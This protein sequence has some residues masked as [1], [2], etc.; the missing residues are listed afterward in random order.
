V[1]GFGRKQLWPNFKVLSQHSLGGTEQ[2]QEKPQS[3]L[4]VSRSRF[5]PEPPEYEAG[6]FTTHTHTTSGAETKRLAYSHK[7]NSS[8]EYFICRGKYSDTFSYN[9]TQWGMLQR[10]NATMNSFYQ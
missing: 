1:K 6:V 4:A 3:G 5:E 9:Y 10:T 8:K 7:R 2:N